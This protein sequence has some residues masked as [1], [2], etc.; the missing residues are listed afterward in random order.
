MRCAMEVLMRILIARV[1]MPLLTGLLPLGAFAGA[2]PESNQVLLLMREFD[3][4]HPAA[5]KLAQHTPFVAL[6]LWSALEDAGYKVTTASENGERGFIN[7]ND[8]AVLVDLAA[9]DVNVRDYAAIVLPC[10]TTLLYLI[11]DTSAVP[12]VFADNESR[13]LQRATRALVLLGAQHEGSIAL[14]RAGVLDDRQFA[15]YLDPINARFPYQRD[16]SFAEAI[17]AGTDLVQDG[18]VITS[19]HCGPLG[20]VYNNTWTE[21]HEAKVDEFVDAILAGIGA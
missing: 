12:F 20:V 4:D 17:Y 5:Q 14:A 16:E 18:N 3:R 19:A 15:Y 9:A 21:E 2:A 1:A 8:D 6:R 7:P 10:I 13:L 11:D